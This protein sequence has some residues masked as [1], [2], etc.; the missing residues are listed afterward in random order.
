MTWGYPSFRVVDR[1]RHQALPRIVAA[2]C[3]G[4]RRR[5][6]LETYP[7][8]DR[9]RVEREQCG[10]LIRTWR[11]SIVPFAPDASPEEIVKIVIDLDEDR[12]VRVLANGT[13]AHFEDCGGR[14]RVRPELRS[15][16]RLGGSFA[17]EIAYRVPPGHPIVRSLRPRITREAFP[18]GPPPHLLNNL[19]ALCILFPADRFWTWER[20]GARE[21]ANYTAIWLAKHLAWVEARER[22]IPVEVAWPGA[23]VGHEPWE[24]AALIGPKDPCRCGSGRAYGTCCRPRDQASRAGGLGGSAA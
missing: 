24:V 11:G 14:H 16:R 8:D 2:L 3:A 15:E 21:Y 4:E 13:L 17:I 7:E 18:G 9:E 5:E 12:P 6:V 1:F 10:D 19:E 23:F 20:H 22:G